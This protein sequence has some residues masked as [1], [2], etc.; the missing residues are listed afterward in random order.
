M[1]LA[2]AFA[3]S[4]AEPAIASAPGVEPRV[5]GGRAAGEGEAPWTVSIGWSLT[6]ASDSDLQRHF[7]GGT[8]VSPLVVA[9]AA[10]CVS[11]HPPTDLQVVT[12]T[13]DL[14]AGG[15]T[16]FNVPTVEVH[17]GF[18][19]AAFVNDVALL[20]LS[21]P[22][23]GPE[24]HLDTPG[25]S[26]LW[27][28]MSTASLAGWGQPSEN[29]SASGD[30][31][32]AELPVLRDRACARAYGSGCRANSMLC[33]GR[34]SGGVDSCQGDSGGPLVFGNGSSLIGIVSWG[35]GCARPGVPGVYTRVGGPA[36]ASWL[37]RRIDALSGFADV[38]APNTS[39]R[40]THVRP[41][42][43][44]PWIRFSAP[45]DA[46]VRFQCRFDR[47]PYRPCDSPA[48]PQRPLRAG[49]HFL[50]VLA[51]DAAGNREPRAARRSF[52]V[53]ERQRRQN[54]DGATPRPP[55]RNSSRAR[56][57]SRR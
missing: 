34:I 4:V 20:R 48:R 46:G 38:T 18:R 50:Q 15:G 43:H 45:G 26:A 14:A 47:G 57:S 1:L 41:G 33:A 49:R 52:R 42:T 11:E 22:A 16:D 9:T 55:R 32:V 7:C 25:S 21:S 12:G 51:T 37:R 44:R 28:P 53:L 56:G 23:A 27:A 5:V 35:R 10:H 17:P 31:M 54:D 39:I 30:L 29:G 3:G 36:L 2:Q 24:L 19:P 6:R 40:Q 13:R 8:L